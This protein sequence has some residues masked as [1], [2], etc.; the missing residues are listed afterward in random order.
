MYREEIYKAKEKEKEATHR[1]N[2]LKKWNSDPGK[3]K[4]M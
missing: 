4:N 1:S 3:L 2:Y